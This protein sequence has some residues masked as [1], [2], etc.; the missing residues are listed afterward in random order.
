[1]HSIWKPPGNVGKSKSQLL[2]ISKNTKTGA[3]L[4]IS[5]PKKE[6]KSIAHFWLQNIGKG[7]ILLKTLFISSLDGQDGKD[8]S[9]R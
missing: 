8:N 2:K 3:F 4:V 6:R 9:C 5:S 7:T 1:V